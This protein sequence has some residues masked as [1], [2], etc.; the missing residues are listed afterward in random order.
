MK[1]ESR[2]LYS[3]GQ[4]KEIFLLQIPKLVCQ[5]LGLTKDTLMDV[6][7]EDGNIIIK[8]KETEVNGTDIA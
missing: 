1:F 4:S 5:D 2:K 3:H 7:Y 6:Y 8:K